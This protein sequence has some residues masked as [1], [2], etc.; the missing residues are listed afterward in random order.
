MTLVSTDESKDKQEKY[1]E[2]WSKIKDFIRSTNNNWDGYDEKYKKVNL[3]SD[4]DLPLRK[5]LKLYD[6][7]IVRS[8]FNGGNK[9]YPQVFLNNYLHKLA[10]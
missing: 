10:E 5:I 9:Y 2:K 8:V 7:I 3:N 4:G 1:E 6:I